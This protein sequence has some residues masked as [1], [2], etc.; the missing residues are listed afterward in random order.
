MQHEKLQ[1]QN[2]YKQ[3]SVI[4]LSR[5]SINANKNIKFSQNDFE[6]KELMEADQYTTSMPW[7]F[8]MHNTII[9]NF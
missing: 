2:W 4:W 6:S 3:I 7:L 9:N 1:M 8:Y 5:N